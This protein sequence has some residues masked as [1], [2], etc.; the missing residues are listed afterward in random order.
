MRR[1]VTIVLYSET[2]PDA[3]LVAGYAAS[4]RTWP[5]AFTPAL[6]NT[7]TPRVPLSGESSRTRHATPSASDKISAPFEERERAA[8]KAVRHEESAVTQGEEVPA[9]EFLLYVDAKYA[10]PYAMSAFVA[11]QEKGLPFE[12]LAIDLAARENFAPGFAATSLTCRVP[13]LVH[14]DFSLSESSAISEYLEDLYPAPG[15]APVYPRDVRARAR[16]RQIQAWLRSDLMPIR[17]ERPTTVIFSRRTDVSLSEEGRIAAE[18]LFRVAD[19]LLAHGGQFLFGEW[20][21]ADVDLAVMI[22]RLAMNGDEVPSRLATY[23][24]SQWQR[25]SVQRWVKQ[26]RETA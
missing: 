9:A 1:A 6:P 24:A 18:K 26:T 11:L 21:I 7:E 20:S 13:T 5:C 2:W 3:A 23:A 8:K 22:N 12:L 25:A 15:Y 16:A 19:V 14:D 10:S 17:S 4:S